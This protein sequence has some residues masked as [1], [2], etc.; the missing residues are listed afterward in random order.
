MG[1]LMARKPCFDCTED[2][3]CHMNCGPAIRLPEGWTWDRVRAERTKWGLSDD[4]VPL[5]VVPGQCVAWVSIDSIKE[6][7][8]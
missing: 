7:S 1:A 3:G 8:K 6:F 4:I 2:F 5:A